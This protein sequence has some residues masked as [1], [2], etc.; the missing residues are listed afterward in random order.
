[1]WNNDPAVP[2]FSTPMPPFAFG[3][4]KYDNWLVH[5]AIASGLRHVIDGSDSLT[6]IHVAHSYAHVKAAEVKMVGGFWST[7]KKSS[8][9]LFGNIHMAESHGSYTN[10]K[11]TALHAPW[12][13]TACWEPEGERW[14]AE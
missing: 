13:L 2:L 11:G 3:R 8:W 6:S 5:E 1:M 12:K 9:E 4:G 14:G 7:R 10:Q